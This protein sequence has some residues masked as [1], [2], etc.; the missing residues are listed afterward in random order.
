MGTWSRPL[1]A[2]VSHGTPADY[3][4][5]R[6]KDWIGTCFFPEEDPQTSFT[7]EEFM[8]TGFHAHKILDYMD[9]CQIQRWSSLCRTLL[10][11]NPVLEWVEFHFYSSDAGFPFCLRF[12]RDVNCLRLCTAKERDPLFTRLTRSWQAWWRGY[13]AEWIFLSE[14]YARSLDRVTFKQ[15][16]LVCAFAP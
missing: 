15:T 16:I 13:E 12:S 9:H 11:E 1:F 10:A 2:R 3:C 7:L 6:T 8:N 5:E 4:V 14:E